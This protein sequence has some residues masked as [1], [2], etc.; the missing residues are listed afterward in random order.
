MAVGNII[1]FP[2]FTSTSLKTGF[3]PTNQALKLNKID[4]EK[5][6]IEMIMRYRHLNGN[7]SPGIIILHS[8]Q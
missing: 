8:S 4:K 1:V 7:I 2:A 6:A 5:I 3:S